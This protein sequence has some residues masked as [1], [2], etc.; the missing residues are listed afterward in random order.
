M[1]E[2]YIKP[3]VIYVDFHQYFLNNKSVMVD[4]WRVVNDNSRIICCTWVEGIDV[5][6]KSPWYIKVNKNIVEQIPV[7]I[8]KEPYVG[9]HYRNTDMKTDLNSVIQ[10][11]RHLPPEIQTLYL[12]TDD[13]TAF[14]AFNSAIGY[15]FK[16]VQH[17]KPFNDGGSNIHYGN[18]NKDE[19]ILN[20]LIDI[21]N[22]SKAAHF[23]GNNKSGLSRKVEEI[24]ITDNFFK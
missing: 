6:G 12:S 15:R 21:Y 2:Q 8:I 23:I 9:V 20:T 10:K 7:N 4:A 14:D 22:L 13:Y 1:F 3:E 16:I 11:V 24:R 18:P 17:T 5:F 19:I